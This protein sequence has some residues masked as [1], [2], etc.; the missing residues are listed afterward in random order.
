MPASASK[1]RTENTAPWHKKPFTI[2]YD[3]ERSTNIENFIATLPEADRPRN[4][5]ELLVKLLGTVATLKDTTPFEQE[6]DR[7]KFNNDT[8]GNK[9]G[10]L[11]K[12]TTGLQ[13]EMERLQQEN[14]TLKNPETIRQQWMESLQAAAPDIAK[15]NDPTLEAALQRF[16]FIITELNQ[17]VSALQQRNSDLEDQLNEAENRPVLLKPNEA[18]VSFTTEQL[19]NIRLIRQ[20]MEKMGHTFK[21]KEPSEVIHLAMEQN[22]QLT[23]TMIE[24]VKEFQPLIELLN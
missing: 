5:T 18:I 20:M 22:I 11:E 16:V 15:Y 7:L 12:E 23:R 8:L 14:E 17:Q 10:D 2:K 4:A 19:D 1:A 3:L 13:E 9:L 21:S 6:I 24:Q